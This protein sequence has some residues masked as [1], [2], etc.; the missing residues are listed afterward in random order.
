MQ[1]KVTTAEIDSNTSKL[2]SADASGICRDMIATDKGK[3]LDTKLDEHTRTTKLRR[4]SS[5]YSGLFFK[6]SLPNQRMTNK[7]SQSLFQ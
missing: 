6:E 1:L 3:R 7:M 4:R 2:R 5:F